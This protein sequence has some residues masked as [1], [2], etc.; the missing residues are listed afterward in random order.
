MTAKGMGGLARRVAALEGR[1]NQQ[2][3][4]N[5]F[6]T[7]FAEDAPVTRVECGDMAFDQKPGES[8]DELMDRAVGEAKRLPI[9]GGAR[10]FYLFTKHNI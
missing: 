5:V 9:E 3:G 4:L 8:E 7:R 2:D 10:V 6:I 1:Y